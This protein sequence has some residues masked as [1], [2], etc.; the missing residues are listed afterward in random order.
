MGNLLSTLFAHPDDEH[1]RKTA[2]DRTIEVSVGF[3]PVYRYN[4]VAR[5]GICVSDNRYVML[6][7]PTNLGDYVMSS[8]PYRTA[9]R[10]STDKS[11]PDIPEVYGHRQSWS[12]CVAKSLLTVTRIR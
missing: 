3:D 11:D 6:C 10:R 9:G 1:L 8:H 12:P 5:D 2:L 4:G 7:G